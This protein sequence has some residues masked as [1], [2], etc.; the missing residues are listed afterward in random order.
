MKIDLSN[1]TV[2]ENLRIIHHVRDR[3]ACAADRMMQ[4]H[5]QLVIVMGEE[6]STIPHV[7][8]PLLVAQAL[9]DMGYTD[10][11][12]TCELEHD[13]CAKDFHG[14][15]RD[16]LLNANADAEG[17]LSIQTPLASKMSSEAN[18][19]KLSLH[20]SLYAEGYKPAC[21]DLSKTEGR[22]V[23]Q[24]DDA[25]R[26]FA[27]KMKIYQKDI[28]LRSPLGMKL[29]DAFMAQQIESFKKPGRIIMHQG[30]RR[31]AIG[32]AREFAKDYA[33]FNKG[34]LPMQLK[35]KGLPTLVAPFWQS[36]R[37]QHDVCPSN[38]K[39]FMEKPQHNLTILLDLMLPDIRAAY[40][41]R[42]G[43]SAKPG[44]LNH[45]QEVEWLH[46]HLP[47]HSDIINA[48][49]HLWND[50][51]AFKNRPYRQSY[52]NKAEKILEAVRPAAAPAPSP[53]A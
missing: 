20:H 44:Y 42:I 50:D 4:R 37:E 40:D 8:I 11:K 53:T 45:T 2:A 33:P 48:Y 38:V 26:H 29:R 34:R 12:A 49:A 17:T 51:D 32:N 21:I 23:N 9:R 18:V 5:G 7:L 24:D 31:H 46:A 30:G 14:V 41:T 35:N 10:I 28:C 22:L 16:A 6:H 15:E 47:D 39:T 13:M 27:Q 43:V 36:V 52:L 25:T 19:T 1:D 3:I